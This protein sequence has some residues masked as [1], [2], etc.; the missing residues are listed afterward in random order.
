MRMI[1]RL[2]VRGTYVLHNKPLDRIS[3]TRPEGMH[4]MFDD[5]Q[6]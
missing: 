2:K 6:L 1:T 4:D 5:T 3:Y